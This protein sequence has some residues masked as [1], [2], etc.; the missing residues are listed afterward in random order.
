[1]ANATTRSRVWMSH[2]N[3]VSSVHMALFAVS[4]SS[5]IPSALGSDPF[6]P[7]ELVSAS[8]AT[9]R[10]Q[11]SESAEITIKLRLLT[12]PPTGTAFHE[13]MAAS[14]RHLVIVVYYGIW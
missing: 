9:Q 5:W 8:A 12:T 10:M 4:L 6:Q 3:T 7:M 11:R 13:N 1:M 14:E 2:A